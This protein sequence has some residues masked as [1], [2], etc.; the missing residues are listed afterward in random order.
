M[1]SPFR[2]V[3]VVAAVLLA[4]LVPNLTHAQAP[5]APAAADRIVMKTGESQVGRILGV[6]DGQVQLQINAGAIGFPLER[7]ASVE[8]AAPPALA[9]AQAAYEKGDFDA[10]LTAVRPVAEGFRGLPTDWARTAA[11]LLGDLYVEKNDLPRAEAA[12]NELRRFYGAAAGG[13]ARV[14]VGQARVLM[15]RKNP[16]GARQLL[17]P[18]AVAA[19]KDPVR[20]SR[21]DGAAY[22]QT[23]FLLGQIREGA[24][25]A[26]G[27]LESYLR[28][29]TLF[30]SQDRNSAASA[31]KAA[32]AL[33]AKNP[34]LIAP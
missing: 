30:A 7:I 5:A 3:V 23:F 29:A 26:P 6:R 32:D 31:Q 4:V 20:V 2:S 18:L 22:G 19:L 17:E 10:A 15:A 34:G 8:M 27:A 1:F 25:D 14:S 33:R 24:G 16:A 13:S 9:A 12:Y 11:G 28:A 21:S